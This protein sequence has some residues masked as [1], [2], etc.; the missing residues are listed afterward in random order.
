MKPTLCALL[1]LLL[2]TPAAAGPITISG[3]DPIVF[4]DGQLVGGLTPDGTH[5]YVQSNWYTLVAD[6]F[7]SDD[8]NLVPTGDF[9]V[10]QFT[11]SLVGN[12]HTIYAPL[13]A[14]AGCRSG[15]LD[16]YFTGADPHAPNLAVLFHTPTIAGDEDCGPPPVCPDCV[17]TPVCVDCVNT[18]IPEPASLLLLGTGLFG[19]ARARKGR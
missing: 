11:S 4:T 18:P 10:A 9:L 7:Y 19:V 14:V 16:V 15:Q 5:I 13:P 2:S 8:P 12:W 6:L 1:L 17:I 3:T